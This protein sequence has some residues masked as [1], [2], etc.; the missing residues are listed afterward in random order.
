MRNLLLAVFLFTIPAMGEMPEYLKDGV[1]TVTL[2]NGETHTFSSN[3]FK[4]V[5]RVQVKAIEN[6][7][8]AD[9]PKA[10][11]SKPLPS[12][13][14]VFHAGVG[15]DGLDVSHNGNEFRV[16][17]KDAVVGGLTLC[18]RFDKET[19]LCASGFTNKTFTLGV[20]LDF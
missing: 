8:I 19:S 9:A 2:A 14:V 16:Q 15:R 4:V 1:V 10:N 3:E 7:V 11:E 5:P 12:R 13:T 18:Q 6:T 17:E 20:G